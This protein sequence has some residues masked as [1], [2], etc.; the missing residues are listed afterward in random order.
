MDAAAMSA[1]SDVAQQ[2]AQAER[3]VTRASLILDVTDDYASAQKI[4][5]GPVRA[6]GPLRFSFTER[7]SGAAASQA[8]DPPLRLSTITNPSGYHLWFGE[9]HG[10]SSR[11]DAGS[12]RLRIDSDAY[13]PYVTPAPVAVPTSDSAV[14]C[15]L[16]PGYAYP[17]AGG[18]LT[19]P[20]TTPTLLRGVVQNYDGSGQAGAT[21]AVSAGAATLG[22]LTDATGQFVV[23]IPDPPPASVSVTITTAGGATTLPDLAITA[24]TTTVVPQ[25]MLAGRVVTTVL[26]AT[27]S[28]SAPPVTVPTAPDGSWRIVLPPDQTAGT[29]TVT[30]RVPGMRTKSRSKV[31]V[32][33]GQTVTVP[34]F[35][36]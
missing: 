31:N 27:V 11:P 29:V 24:A 25:T 12:Y 15:P 3:Q 6:S 21:I 28:L 35:V 17:F 30:A 16:R 26:G 5:G 9:V 1:A 20:S 32:V 33:P 34:T 19:A 36:F 13:A 23:V 8:L 4:G 10:G 7:V 18:G 14:A 22:Y 2:L